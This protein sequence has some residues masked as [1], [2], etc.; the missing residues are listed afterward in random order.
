MLRR[1]RVFG[2][3]LVVVMVGVGPSAGQ[4]SGGKIVR[5]DD[6]VGATCIDA[7]E[8]RIWLVLRGFVAS[9]SSGWFTKDTSV[10]ALIKTTVRAMGKDPVTFPLMANAAFG[11]GPTGQVSLPIEYPIITGLVL[12]QGDTLIAGTDVQITLLNIKDRTKLGVALG[13][14]ADI[15]GSDKLPIPSSPYFEG[16]KYLLNFA[17]EAL[18]KDLASQKVEDQAITGALTFSFSTS[19]DC[20]GDFET[21]GTKAFLFSEGVQGPGYVSLNRINDY[22]WSSTRIPTFVLRAAKKQPGVDCT[23]SSYAQSFRDVT[24]NYVGLFLNKRTVVRTLGPQNAAERD[25]DESW[26]RCQANG[27]KNR[28]ECPGAET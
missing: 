13:V 28:Q 25:K 22:C 7:Y 1:M 3:V 12:A 23:D 17:N 15:T 27:I 5:V 14:L 10:G 21:T 16:A 24:N 4:L 11:D 8:D 26:K 18:E 9:K 20:T 19:A 2:A 6:G